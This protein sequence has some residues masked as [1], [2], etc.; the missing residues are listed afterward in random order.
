[1]STET[2]QELGVITLRLSKL[3]EKTDVERPALTSHDP[4]IFR[5]LFQFQDV[6]KGLGKLKGY[7]VTLNIDEDAIPQ[8]QP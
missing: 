4:D 8:A 5:I 7:T 2:A 6:V 3:S 1:M